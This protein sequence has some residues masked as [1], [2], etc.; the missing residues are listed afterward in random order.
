MLQ[1][2]DCLP[3]GKGAQELSKVGIAPIPFT[4]TVHLVPSSEYAA[5]SEK[6]RLNLERET[7]TLQSDSNRMG[8]RFD[9]QPLTLSQPLEMLSHAVQAGTVQVPP[10]GKPIILLADAQ[11]TGGYPKIA[12]VAAADLGRLAQVR[13][14][15]KVKFKIIGLKEATALRRKNQAYLNQIRRI[16]HEAG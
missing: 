2:G 1:K 13:F 4:D 15:S 12:T 16:T 7:W 10:G 11:T 9:G 3:I 8:Y 6:G 14:G 5:F